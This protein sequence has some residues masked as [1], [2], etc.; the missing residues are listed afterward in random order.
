MFCLF[1][2]STSFMFLFAFF[3]R[4][5]SLFISSEICSLFYSNGALSLKRNECEHEVSTVEKVETVR[6]GEGEGQGRADHRNIV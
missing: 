1:V 6:M 3:P 5:I 4:K 2:V